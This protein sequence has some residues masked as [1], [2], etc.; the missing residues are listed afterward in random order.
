MATLDRKVLEQRVALLE[1]NHI[2][3]DNPFTRD[4][5]LQAYRLAI[6]G[7]KVLQALS[8]MDGGEL[9]WAPARVG[10]PETRRLADPG[11][12]GLGPKSA[13]SN[14]VPSSHNRYTGQDCIRDYRRIRER[15]GHQPTRRTFIRIGVTGRRYEKL[16]KNYS[17]FL[18]DAK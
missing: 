17:E 4:E 18:K 5:L 7:Q 11:S 13:G 3:L 10:A 6:V 14:P 2:M 16:C 9:K 8:D 1:G 15:L 12:S